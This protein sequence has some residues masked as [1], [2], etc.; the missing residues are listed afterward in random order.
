M[1]YG[2][3]V[4]IPSAPSRDRSVV[5]PST[6]KIVLIV[7]F[8]T[9]L[10][11][12]LLAWGGLGDGVLWFLGIKVLQDFGDYNDRRYQ[13]ALFLEVAANYASIIGLVIALKMDS[14]SPHVQRPTQP[15]YA[16]TPYDAPPP[17]PPPAPRL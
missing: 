1:R 11:A 16:P 8:A 17:P 13:L 9:N 10:L 7:I 2:V 12:H 15:P 4:Y 3:L 14:T 6:T 5:K